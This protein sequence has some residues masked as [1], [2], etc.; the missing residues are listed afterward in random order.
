MFTHS[1]P[2]SSPLQKAKRY[3]P[4]GVDVNDDVTRC[5]VLVDI[6]QKADVELQEKRTILFSS[7]LIESLRVLKLLLTLFE[8]LS[9]A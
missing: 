3:L 2:L 7:I 5:A 4:A 1:R 9:F 8:F 6:K